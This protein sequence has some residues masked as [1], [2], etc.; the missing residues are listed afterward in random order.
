MKRI[1]SLGSIVVLNVYWI[2]LSV[3]WN[4]L[5]PIVLPAILFGLVPAG[6]RNTT[7]GLLTFA[8]LVVA[9][10]V[11]P[12]AG[13]ISDGWRSHFGRR[14]PMMAGATLFDVL[15]LALMAVGGGALAG[16]LL[17]GPAAGSLVLIF[18]GYVGLQLSSNVGQGS[19]QGLLPD[20]VAAERLGLASGIKTLMDIGSLIFISLAAGRLLDP[21][22]HNPGPIFVVI[23]AVVL[24]TVAITVLFT[25]EESTARG[26]R[27]QGGWSRLRSDLRV[28]FRQNVPYWWVIAQ[29]FVFLLGIYGAQAFIQ[30]YLRDALQVTNPVRL[31][32]DLLASMTLTLVLMVV[33]GGWLADRIG[34]KRVLVA[35]GVLVATGLGLLPLA[36]STGLLLA[37]GS[38]AGAGIGLFLT[39]SWAL[40]NKLAP[41]QE[42]GKYLG[43]TNIATAGAAAL[44]RLQGPLIDWANNARP[45][46]WTGYTGMFLFG[47][48][49]SLVSVAMLRYVVVPKKGEFSEIGADEPQELI[50]A[51]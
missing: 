3:K 39:A 13:A 43:L 7:L 20:R 10:L 50:A 9:T 34:S 40:A 31:T 1:A 15:F 29:R 16:I 30:N 18:V 21:Q 2:G 27:L 5:H 33:T 22:G 46:A 45:G 44:A 11:Q 48:L 41:A 37:F 6:Q 51:N 4:A 17:R 8:G 12:L 24:I 36:R 14:R 19:A 49:C 25:R 42:A 38:I 23:I 28:D 26:R 32:G 47:V 35:A